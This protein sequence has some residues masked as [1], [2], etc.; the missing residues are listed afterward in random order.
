MRTYSLHKNTQRYTHRNPARFQEMETGCIVVT[1][2]KLN[3]DGY[4]RVHFNNDLI[5]YHRLVWEREHGRIKEGMEINHKCKNRACCNLEHLECIEGSVHATISNL[6]RD[7]CI[8]QWS[9]TNK[10][11]A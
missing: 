1:N 6:G 11:Q 7:F 4:Y 5:M 10:E 2:R 8:G 3:K 9:H